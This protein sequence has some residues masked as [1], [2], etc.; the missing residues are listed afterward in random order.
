MQGN[1]QNKLCVQKETYIKIIEL[2]S[3]L[4]QAPLKMLP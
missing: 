2:D 1:S 4:K 3:K